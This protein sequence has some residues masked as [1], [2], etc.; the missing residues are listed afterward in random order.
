MDMDGI[1]HGRTS[2]SC[3][4]KIV[5]VAEPVVEAQARV[6][7]TDRDRSSDIVPLIDTAI[8]KRWPE[9]THLHLDFGKATCEGQALS[10]PF[11]GSTVPAK[12]SGSGQAITGLI[13]IKTM[14]DY[15]ITVEPSP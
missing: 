14:S 2:I 11:D 13:R 8:A 12:G 3:A 1:C 6:L 15:R 4:E 7:F 5:F 9:R 10:I